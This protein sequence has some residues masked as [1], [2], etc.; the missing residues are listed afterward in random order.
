VTVRLKEQ[1]CF[2][3]ACSLSFR[4]FI[5][6]PRDTSSNTLSRDARLRGKVTLITGATRGIGLAIARALAAEGCDLILTG[7]DKFALARAGRG[8]NIQKNSDCAQA[9][10]VRDP[11]S[12][13]ALSRRFAVNSTPGYSH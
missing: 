11:R 5:I 9:C 7:R 2:A 4:T 3:N 8:I 6:L 10:D 13:D 1:R 12:V